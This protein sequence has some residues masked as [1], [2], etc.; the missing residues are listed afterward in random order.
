MNYK[1]LGFPLLLGTLTLGSLSSSVNSQDDSPP[2]PPQ[3]ITLSGV[4]RDFSD[5]HPDFERNPGD[6]SSDGTI[7]NYGLD[8]DIVTNELNKITRKP[9]YAGGSYSTTNEENFNQWY[10]KVDNVN[11]STPL[12][13]TL[14]RQ[15]DGV[16]RYQN[17]D[18]FPIN[19]QLLGNEGRNKNFHFTYELHTEFDYKGGEVFEFSG[20]DDVWVFINDK[21]VI[22]IG[23]VHSKKDA[24]V[25]LDDVAD[26]IGLVLGSGTK[27]DPY[28]TYKLDFFFAERHTTQSNFIIETTLVLEPQNNTKPKPLAD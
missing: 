14:T 23:G 17:T 5:A 1:K 25:S 3:S 4:I 19:E 9:V 15:E 2:P 8:Q 18:F 13:I 6:M 7:F 21:K 24:S 12:P 20:D 22:D 16:Y 27:D 26:K 10:N 28:N 11:L